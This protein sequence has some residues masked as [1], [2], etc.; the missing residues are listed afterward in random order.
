M[1]DRLIVV[2]TMVYVGGVLLCLLWV[3]W[4]IYLAAQWVRRR[5]NEAYRR[6]VQ[7]IKARERA[8]RFR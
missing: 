7:R 8:E 3:E 4:T 6:S 2:L 1:T 5:L